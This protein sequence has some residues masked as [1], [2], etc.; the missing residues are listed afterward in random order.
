MDERTACERDLTPG[1]Y[2]ALYVTDSGT[3]MAPDV[4]ARAFDL[5]FFAMTTLANRVRQMPD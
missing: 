2:I 5:F 3:G 4:I 1:Q